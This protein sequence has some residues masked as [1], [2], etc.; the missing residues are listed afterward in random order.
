MVRAVAGILGDEAAEFDSEY[1][2]RKIFQRRKRTV[3]F[4]IH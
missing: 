2:S 3:H 4:G 1:C